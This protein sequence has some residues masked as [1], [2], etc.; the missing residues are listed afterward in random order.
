MMPWTP[1]MDIV[2]ALNDD[3]FQSGEE[4]AWFA[5]MSWTLDHTKFRKGKMRKDYPPGAKRR[6]NPQ[7]GEFRA[8]MG[9]GSKGKRKI[10]SQEPWYKR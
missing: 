5:F 3:Y 7:F 6:G 2:L 10:K 9:I 4:I 1:T 8:M